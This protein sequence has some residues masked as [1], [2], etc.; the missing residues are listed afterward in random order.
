MTNLD[1]TFK[2]QRHHFADKGPCIQSYDFSSSHV[3]ISELDG[4][5]DWVLKNW[6]FQTVVMEKILES[7]L[8]SK[9]INPV[10]PKGNLPWIFIGRT[11]AEAEAPVL[12]PPDAK[13]QLIG[14]KTQM[15]GK[16][17]GGRRGGWEDKLARCHRWL[18]GHEFEQTLAES[19]GQGNL[20]CC[21]SWSCEESDMAEQLNNNK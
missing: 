18:N 13:S 7:P 3:Q 6:C 17:E 8:D 19:E 1:S 10:S 16:I 4:K 12:W 9:E 20:A 2:K 15:L 5:E 14:T 11:G 21:S